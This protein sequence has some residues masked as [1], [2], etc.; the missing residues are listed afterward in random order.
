M[1]PDVDWLKIRANQTDS[2][3]YQVENALLGLR[4]NFTVS[5]SRG[6]LIKLYDF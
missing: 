6:L 5:D 2:L 3:Y 1:S 4:K